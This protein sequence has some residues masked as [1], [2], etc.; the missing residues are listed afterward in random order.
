M[1]K[2]LLL[3]GTDITTKHA[4]EYCRQ[5]GVY[6]I[7]TDY[8]P[9]ESST[10][11]QLADE[12]W[13]IDLADLDTLEQACRE[14]GI[15]GVYAGCHEY[16]L[17]QTLLLAKRLGLP[18]YA[19]EESWK[20][21]RDKARFKR[22]CAAVGLDTPHQYAVSQPFTR[23]ML[24]AVQYPVIVKPV[25]SFASKGVTICHS[26]EELIRAYEY[27]LQ[28]SK[29]KR[30]IVEDYIVG[31]EFAPE[32]YVLDGKI[33]F[34][35][36]CDIAYGT[37]KNGNNMCFTLEP[38]LIQQ[39]YLQSCLDKVQA[40]CTRMGCKHGNLYFE[41]IYSNGKFYFLELIHRLSGV[42]IWEVTQKMQGFCAVRRMVCYALGLPD[43]PAEKPPVPYGCGGI[44]FYWANPGTVAKIVGSEE[45]EKIDGVEIILE[46]F[47]VGD[48][49]V[50][51][52]NMSQIA[53][54]ICVA[55]T[56]HT[57][58]YTKLDR[59]TRTLHIYD[60]NGS[61]LTD[62]MLSFDKLDDQTAFYG[63]FAH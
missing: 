1:Q 15:D 43:P 12:W 50:E 57:E 38:S 60:E 30:V 33:H 20:S 37:R 34:T 61:E 22:H 46:R 17:D 40:L 14:K 55:A 45:I 25:D 52:N 42:G 39:Q 6:S 58:F 53:Y 3:M 23:E 18:F 11:K 54:Y 51:C 28:F 7:V 59:I 41:A 44:F 26:E 48:T 32:H 56:D 29:E 13:M 47:H 9:Y 5:I 35:S 21:S 49:V 63:A 31:M 62:P 10:G 16:C 4:I 36:M 8:V 2:K 24:D 19:S 27:A